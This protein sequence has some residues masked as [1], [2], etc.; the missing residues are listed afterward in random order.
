MDLGQKKSITP[1][2]SSI[3]S[4]GRP[5]KKNALRRV[6]KF[7]VQKR[8]KMPVRSRRLHRTGGIG[9]SGLQCWAQTTASFQHRVC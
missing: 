6:Q 7:L 5:V 9:L 3:E 1:L 2:G 8:F 4:H